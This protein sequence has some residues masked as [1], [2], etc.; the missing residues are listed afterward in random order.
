MFT[1]VQNN[2]FFS[3][4]KSAV[5]HHKQVGQ[6]AEG[7]DSARVDPTCSAVAALGAP[8]TRPEKA[9]KMLR[10]LEHICYGD[11]VREM[12]FLSLEKRGFQGVPFNPLGTSEPRLAGEGFLQGHF[13]MV[14]WFETERGEIHTKC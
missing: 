14:E 13:V 3:V 4:D 6:Q 2:V 7:G 5:C 10:R 8:G 12:E 1:V 11:R 9:L